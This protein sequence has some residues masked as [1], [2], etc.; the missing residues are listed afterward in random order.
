[1]FE[2]WC[3]FSRWL[4]VGPPVWGAGGPGRDVRPR[5]VPG[6]RV[7]VRRF[8]DA[9]QVRVRGRQ[10]SGVARQGDSMG[11]SMGDSMGD[12]MA[13]G[14]PPEAFIWRGRLYVVRG[15]LAQW[16]ERRAWW[17]DAL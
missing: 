16:R 13:A 15:V 12:S 9:V 1:M 4:V 7:V 8:S 3:Q 11:G 2:S 10:Q 17:R 6:R 5:R 14:P